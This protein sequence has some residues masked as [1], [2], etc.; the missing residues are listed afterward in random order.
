M[1]VPPVFIQSFAPSIYVVLPLLYVILKSNCLQFGFFF[2]PYRQSS[3][4][5]P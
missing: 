2:L 4:Y 5:P 1:N 3:R